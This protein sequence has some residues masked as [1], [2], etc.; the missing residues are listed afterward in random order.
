MAASPLFYQSWRW[1]ML[2][3]ARLVLITPLECVFFWKITFLRR[4]PG[5]FPACEIT[6]IILICQYCWKTKNNEWASPKA[7]MFFFSFFGRP[8]FRFHMTDVG[9]I[10]LKFACPLFSLVYSSV[11]GTFLKRKLA[12]TSVIVIHQSAVTRSHLLIEFQTEAERQGWNAT[13]NYVSSRADVH[14]ML[15]TTFYLRKRDAH[16][17]VSMTHLHM[18]LDN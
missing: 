13:L 9:Q 10:A 6:C 8:H 11:Q 18:N 16:I 2:T 1:V 7:S 15:A 14:A 3:S 4:S 12:E 17:H 5:L